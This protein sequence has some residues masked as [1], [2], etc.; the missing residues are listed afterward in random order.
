MTKIKKDR[1]V[2]SSPKTL[3]TMMVRSDTAQE[4]LSAAAQA[5]VAMDKK[6]MIPCGSKVSRRK[7]K[8]RSRSEPAQSVMEGFLMKEGGS[9]KS[10]KLRWFVLADSELVYFKSAS[11]ETPLGLLDLADYKLCRSAR[12]KEKSCGIE[13]VPEKPGAR[14]YIMSA[15]NEEERK[16]WV[17]A[18]DS[19]IPTRRPYAQRIALLRDLIH[20]L[21]EIGGTKEDIFRVSGSE[22][23]I[24]RLLHNFELRR[25]FNVEEIVNPYTLSGLIKKILKT[26]AVGPLLPASAQELMQR[27]VENDVAD[28]AQLHSIRAIFNSELMTMDEHK[29]LCDLTTLFHTVLDHAALTNTTIDEIALSFGKALFPNMAD[30][31]AHQ[32]LHLLISHS[33]ELFPDCPCGGSNE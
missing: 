26:C 31:W 21:Q 12:L 15:A 24:K 28:D 11:S 13:L 19:A 22:Q 27:V 10:W 3:R 25:P 14:V 5:V 18:I 23:H 9:H 6:L 7:F 20:H 33:E 32:V 2:A 30:E 29:I 8:G 4:Q 1:D 17:H 16:R